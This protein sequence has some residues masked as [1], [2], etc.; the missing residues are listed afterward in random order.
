MNFLKSI[1][2]IIKATILSIFLVGLIVFMTSN[3]DHISVHL[4]PIPFDIETRVFVVMISFFIFGI[5]FGMIFASQN[6]I[7]AMM[8]DYH[9]KRT[10]KKMVK[11][12][13]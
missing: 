10:I 11:K 7:K 9:N 5:I 2:R 3:R 4:Y 8:K 13:K 1:I 6:A 12:N